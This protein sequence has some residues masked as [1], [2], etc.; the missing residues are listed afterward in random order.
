MLNWF[1]LE[2]AKIYALTLLAIGT[3]SGQPYPYIP[4]RI[5]TSAPGANN[6]HLAP[7]SRDRAHTQQA[8]R[9]GKISEHRR[10]SRR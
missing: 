3:A 6:D 1:G 7:Q 10:G 5:L 9:E 2:V 8:G 4:L